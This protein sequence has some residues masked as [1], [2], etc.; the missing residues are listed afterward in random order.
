MNDE[1][2]MEVFQRAMGA[3]HS[4]E[5]E[6]A[7]RDFIWLQ[8][9]SLEVD[10]GFA[11]VRRSYALAGWIELAKKYQPARTAIEERLAQLTAAQ[12]N[13]PSDMELFQDRTALE[14]RIQRLASM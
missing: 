3:I 8:V 13:R 14:E 11:A 5:H 6:A 2:P 1:R 4:G 9:H 7:L 10:A 12:K